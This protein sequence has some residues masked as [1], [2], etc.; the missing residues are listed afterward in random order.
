MSLP[1]LNSERQQYINYVD[2]LQKEIKDLITRNRELSEKTSEYRAQLVK[3]REKSD[4]LQKR[5]IALNET[6][7]AERELKTT[8]ARELIRELYE[9]TE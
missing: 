2:Q 1:L 4:K 7:T 5:L 3:E 6:I 9:L 8:R